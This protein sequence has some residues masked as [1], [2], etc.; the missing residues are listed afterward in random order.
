MIR[1]PPRSTLSSSSAASDVYKRQ[2]NIIPTRT[3]SKDNPIAAPTCS[4]LTISGTDEKK[5]PF[6]PRPEQPVRKA[7]KNIIARE[8]FMLFKTRPKTKVIKKNKKPI[9]KKAFL[10]SAFKKLSHIRPQPGLPKMLP[11]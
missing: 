3:K 2:V 6:Q 8:L 4:S 11:Y 9:N 10:L 1:R 7:K 5:R